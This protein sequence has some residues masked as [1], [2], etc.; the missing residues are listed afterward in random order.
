M[1]TSLKKI[2]LT[3]LIAGMNVNGLTAVFGTYAYFSDAQV[4]TGN[5]FN[6]ATLDFAV[7]HSWSYDSDSDCDPQTEICPGWGLTDTVGLAAAG[8][9]DFQ[10]TISIVNAAEIASST[11]PLCDYLTVNGLSLKSFV[12]APAL[13]SANPAAALVFSLKGDDR[14]LE[15]Q[16]CNFDYLIQGWQADGVA[17]YG[18]GFFVEKTISSF[19]T[20]DPWTVAAPVVEDEGGT[21]E[22]NDAGGETSDGLAVAG[23][24][25]DGDDIDGDTD[26]D[27]QVQEQGEENQESEG[28]AGAEDGDEGDSADNDDSGDDS[29]GGGASDADDAVAGDG[30]DAGGDDQQQGSDDG[31]V[32]M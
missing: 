1:A 12:S 23:E 32:D 18:Q 30:G 16:T 26:G 21:E 29:N 31:G 25:E 5:A 7:Q 11:M 2:I 13:Y 10:Y 24:S 20:S 17:G 6:A 22:E 4:S 9:L 15:D 14:A 28:G 27:G 19:I 3:L 8:T